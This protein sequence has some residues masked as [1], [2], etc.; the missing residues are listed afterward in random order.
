MVWYRLLI[1][2]VILWILLFFG[3]KIQALPLKAIFRISFVGLM[4]TLHWLFL[5]GAIKCSNVSVTLGCL[6]SSALFTALLEPLFSGKKIYPAE[7]FFGI[8]AIAGIYLIF[9]FQKLHTL[10]IMLALISAGLGSLFTIFNKKLVNDYLPETVTLYEFG[11]GFIYLSLLLPAYL[12]FFPASKLIPSGNDWGYLFFL[13]IVC[14]IVPFI[15]SLIA[16]KH[17]S[18]FTHSITIN[19]EPVYSIVLAI[20]IFKENRNLHT[21]FYI[22]TAVILCSVFLHTLYKTSKTRVRV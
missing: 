13:S 15:L 2:S 18:A 12:Y 8:L 22:G 5:Y 1:S 21:G 11:S 6:A 9:T 16:L 4:I 17:I 14:T 10:G 19:L 20:F 7:I 3:K